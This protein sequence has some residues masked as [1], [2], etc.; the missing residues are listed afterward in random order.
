MEA[1]SDACMSA[2]G[3]ASVIKATMR[4]SAPQFRQT[5][6]GDGNGPYTV[7]ARR[8]RA[9]KVGLGR[10]LCGLLRPL[11]KWGPLYALGRY[12]KFA[13]MQS[14]ALQRSLTTGERRPPCAGALS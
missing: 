12:A 4:L 13:I 2:T 7:D 1:I 10:Q 8:P 3:A 9:G 11:G 6:G 5:R 14:C